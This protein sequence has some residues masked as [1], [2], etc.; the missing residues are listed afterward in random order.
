MP[1]ASIPVAPMPV[2]NA[3]GLNTGGPNAAVRR[4]QRRSRVPPTY[5]WQW[6]IEQLQQQHRI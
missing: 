5:Y 2:A 4:T 1:V 6:H 3:S